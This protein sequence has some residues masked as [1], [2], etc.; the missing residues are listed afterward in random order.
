MEVADEA[1]QAERIGSASMQAVLAVKSSG[2]RTPP[3]G[4]LLG[5]WEAA[6]YQFTTSCFTVTHHQAAR[7][8]R[9]GR[10]TKNN[11]AT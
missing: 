2:T 5:T 10:H 4:S 7:V 8:K 1:K 9:K 6:M 3:W 11:A